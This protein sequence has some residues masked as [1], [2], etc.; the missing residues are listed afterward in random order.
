[1]LTLEEFDNIKP[2]TTFDTGLLVD[3]YEGL[4]MSG[5]KKILRWVAVKGW[6]NDWCIYAHLSHHDE[7]FVKASGD[8]VMGEENIMMAVPC[9]EDVLNR[10]RY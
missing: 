3:S 2:G 7:E 5:S 6:A 8:K 10:Y 9:V 1:M 4:N